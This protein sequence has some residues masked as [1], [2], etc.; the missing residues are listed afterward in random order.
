MVEARSVGGG[1]V[2]RGGSA[3][4]LPTSQAAH[5]PSGLLYVTDLIESTSVDKDGHRRITR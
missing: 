5:A 4:L 2:G 1:E 3:E